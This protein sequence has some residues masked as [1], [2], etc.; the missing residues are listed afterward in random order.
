MKA[1]P[2]TKKPAAK[3]KSAA[4]LRDLPA[5]K[6]ATGGRKPNEQNDK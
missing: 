1:K 3:T 6:N 2:S 4:D 5:K